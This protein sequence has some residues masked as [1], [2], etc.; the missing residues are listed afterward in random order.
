MLKQ[1]VQAP[2]EEEHKEGVIA[3]HQV[4]GFLSRR[5]KLILA[6][7]A[8][9]VMLAVLVLFSLTP[10]YTATTQILL[11]PSD[12][13]GAGAD[14]VLA[15]FVLT[16]ATIDSQLSLISSTALLSRVVDK[17]HLA[18]D[19]EFGGTG[20]RSLVRAIADTLS[21]P[22]SHPEP[23][24][25]PAA[26]DG[27]PPAALTP[28]QL[29][30]IGRLRAALKVS[31]LKL[32]YVI[33]ISVTSRDR[34]KAAR[35][36]NAVAQAYAVDQLEARYENAQRA[37]EWLS[38]RL[39]TLANELRDSDAA[40]AAFR[41]EHN[42]LTT[43][44]GTVTAQQLSELNIKLAAARTETGAAAARYNQ[45]QAARRNG[46]DVASLPDVIRSNVIADLRRQQAE[47][48]R[49]EADLVA[50]YGARHP[51]VVNVRAE[52]ADINA[53]LAAETKR[54]L[55]TIQHDYE[56][57]KAQQAALE[58][59][60]AQL[61]GQS[62]V[63]ETVSVK[64]RELQRVSD[65]NRTLYEN[66]LSRAKLAGEYVTFDAPDSRIITAAVPPG[67]PSY[68]PKLL[69]L[70]GSAV[71]G[72]AIGIG[73]A[74]VIELLNTGF[75]WPGQVTETLGLPILAR[76]P[77][78][79]LAR[80]READPPQDGGERK[81]RSFRLRR[82]DSRSIALQVASKP[83]S[84]YSEAIR[85]LRT[86]IHMSDVDHPPKVI[87]ATS[88]MP[89]EGKSTIMASLA[90]SYALSGSRAVLLDCD[91]RK[92]SVSYQFGLEKQAGLVDLLLGTVPVEQ[93]VVTDEA[94]GLAIIPAGTETQ[95]PQDLLASG[96]MQ[97]LMRQLSASYDFVL[98]DGPPLGPL[99]DAL[100]LSNLVE[101]IVFV[102]QW[103]ATPRQHALEAVLSIRDRHKIAGAAISKIDESA[104]AKYGSYHR[105]SGGYYSHYGDYYQRDRN[106]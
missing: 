17:E 13:K 21:A 98:V 58:Q 86:G 42:L 61:T 87:M 101:K 32:T 79:P 40:V 36:A 63:D 81:R 82:D 96:R 22:F 78:V 93:C 4:L 103:N 85:T 26:A 37:S 83:L 10:Y 106:A 3:V 73:A 59:S 33:E 23:A 84:Q 77:S 66:F 8:G 52:A 76:I 99:A 12:T 30:A 72:L 24:D 56:V 49:K 104:A 19:P 38:D 6:Y 31:R 74:V 43:N 75:T 18:G 97:N 62:G 54:I 20:A 100:I 67:A 94:T 5:W 1:I 53:A 25:P 9:T 68:P 15:E 28:Q 34:T 60:I 27:K 39:A 55:D 88:A 91:L 51:L 2:V 89:G 90:L 11:N 105:L 69:A 16:N 71:L 102:V 64:L 44:T 48:T 70:L 95:T 29:A 65:A 45:V 14:K 35:L 80:G 7:T 41:K 50:H 46:T 92:K 47:V 57:A